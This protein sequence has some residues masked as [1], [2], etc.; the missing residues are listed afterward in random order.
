MKRVIVTGGERG[1][2]GKSTVARILTERF[3]PKLGPRVFRAYDT[4]SGQFHRIY[5][6]NVVTAVDPR[7]IDQMA[8]IVDN[9]LED[10]TGHAVALLDVGANMSDH[11]HDWLITSGTAAFAA[12]QKLA[13]HIVH[14][15]GG[16]VESVKALY[17]HLREWRDV[18]KTVSV[19]RNFGVAPHFQDYDA[20]RTAGVVK[21]LGIP[22]VDLPALDRGMYF[23]IDSNSITFA[24]FIAAK[25]LAMKPKWKPSPS[26]GQTLKHWLDNS[27]R[28]FDV[29]PALMVNGGLL[30]ATDFAAMAAVSSPV[31]ASSVSASTLLTPIDP[32]D[33]LAAAGY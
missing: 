4:D 27:Q 10:T 7:N 15:M 22:V 31:V 26:K 5:G 13:I 8:A 1:G 23:E 32:I 20:S 17:D 21:Q 24:D 16:S 6:G 19:V 30:A 29:V 33:A 12:D 14:V 9:L 25:P 3:L 11:I 28:A 2:V 18:P